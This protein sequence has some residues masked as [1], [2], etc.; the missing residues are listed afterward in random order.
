MTN[1]GIPYF[2]LN[3]QLDEKWEL[4]EA[5]YGLTGFAVAVKL[6]QRIYGEH[7]Y[8]CDKLKSCVVVEQFVELKDTEQIEDSK[9]AAIAGIKQGKFGI[10]INTCDKVKALELLGKHLG[11]SLIR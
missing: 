10:E 1:S 8:Y 2:P 6:L 11:I 7:G 3:C 5:E 9:K 4:I